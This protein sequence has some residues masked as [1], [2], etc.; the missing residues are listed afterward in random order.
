MMV[1]EFED[2][3]PYL[4]NSHTGEADIAQDAEVAQRCDQ[5]RNTKICCFVYL[6]LVFLVYYCFQLKYISRR[7]CKYLWWQRLKSHQLRGIKAQLLVSYVTGEKLS[8]LYLFFMLLSAVVRKCS[9]Q[10]VLHH[11]SLL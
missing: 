4:L 5:K 3:R 8:F 9:P 10:A 2:M 1:R 7:H 11:K 6:N